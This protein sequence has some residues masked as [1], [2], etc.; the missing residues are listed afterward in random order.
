M[1]DN[2]KVYGSSCLTLCHLMFLLEI[3]ASPSHC[4]S[5]RQLFQLFGTPWK[6]NSFAIHG[7][8]VVDIHARIEFLDE[9][10]GITPENNALA[11]LSDDNGDS[12]NRCHCASNFLWIFMIL[13]DVL[14]AVWSNFEI[15]DLDFWRNETYIKFFDFLDQKGGFYYEVRGRECFKIR[16]KKRNWIARLFSFLSDGEMHLF[17]ASVPLCLP[18]RTKSTS[19]RILATGTSR[20]NTVRR[21]R[22]THAG[23]AGVTR[24]TTSVRM[25]MRAASP[26]CGCECSHVSHFS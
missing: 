4:M 3:K 22:P 17:I 11:F 16:W 2:N 10:P 1:E 7:R 12:Y 15:G 20:S 26:S 18:G 24:T 25:S 13:M 8:H 5:M 6:V 21:E 19:S 14:M 9:N 23:N